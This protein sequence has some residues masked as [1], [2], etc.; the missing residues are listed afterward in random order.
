MGFGPNTYLRKKHIIDLHLQ[1][2]LLQFDFLLQNQ[3]FS[4]GKTIPCTE[5]L[6]LERLLAFI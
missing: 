3:L 6:V 1:V 4:F 2:F 5:Y